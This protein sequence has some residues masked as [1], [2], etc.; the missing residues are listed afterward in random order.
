M[1]DKLASPQPL[2][3]RSLRTRRRSDAGSAQDFCVPR[4]AAAQAPAAP[5]RASR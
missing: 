5:A 4:M 2:S 3:G 1:R